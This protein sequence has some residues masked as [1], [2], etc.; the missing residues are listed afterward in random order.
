LSRQ[1]LLFHGNGKRDRTPFPLTIR[2][3]KRISFKDFLYLKELFKNYKHK[4]TKSKIG[5]KNLSHKI[6]KINKPK[7]KYTSKANKK[8][9]TIY[10]NYEPTPIH[11][12]RNSS[13]WQWKRVREWYQIIDDPCENINIKK[14][15]DTYNRI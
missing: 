14:L 15:T 13:Y 7:Q 9:N 10:Y 1:F 12:T 4:T 5:L 3:I 8:N 6:S 2:K 11:N